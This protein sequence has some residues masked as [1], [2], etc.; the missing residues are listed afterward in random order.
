MISINQ[1][2]INY[3]YKKIFLHSICFYAC[4]SVFYMIFELIMYFFA[5]GNIYHVVTDVWRTAIVSFYESNAFSRKDNFIFRAAKELN[6][7]LCNLETSKK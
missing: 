3:N 7:S 2:N 4:F 6:S 5:I 1:I